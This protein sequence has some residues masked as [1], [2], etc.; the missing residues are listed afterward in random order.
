MVQGTWDNVQDPTILIKILTISINWD[1]P[2]LPLITTGAPKK[3]MHIWRKLLIT[4]LK[5]LIISSLGIKISTR[6]SKL[7]WQNWMKAWH[8]LCLK[9]TLMIMEKL[10]TPWALIHPLR[11]EYL[12]L[13]SLMSSKSS[14]STRTISKSSE[15]QRNGR[16]WPQWPI[17][18]YS[19]SPCFKSLFERNH[20][21]ASNYRVVSI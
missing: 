7:R 15:S 2:N 1:R 11:Q 6:T 12:P 17:T 16:K 5:I 13:T 21:A 18:T 3:W 9:R 19:L 14:T 10:F 8:N 20:N 4:K